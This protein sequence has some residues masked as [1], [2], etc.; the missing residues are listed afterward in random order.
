MVMTDTTL[1]GHML[2]KDKLLSTVPVILSLWRY[3]RFEAANSVNPD[4]KEKAI[5]YVLVGRRYR[6]N[7][8]PELVKLGEKW[9]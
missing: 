2:T 3:Y 1:A 5:H 9:L 4:F 8:K 7:L 6:V